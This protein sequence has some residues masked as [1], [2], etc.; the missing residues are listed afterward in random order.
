MALFLKYLSKLD[1]IVAGGL[2]PEI[3]TTYFRVGHMGAVT[4]SD[5]ISTL[6]A[7]EFAL[8]KSGFAFESGI[9]LSTFQKILNTSFE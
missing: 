9:G 6:S 4:S 8:V 7:I 2:L 5:M 3:K 1:V